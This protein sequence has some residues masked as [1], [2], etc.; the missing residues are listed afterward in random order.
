MNTALKIPMFKITKWIT[1]QN[2]TET[3]LDL[4]LRG[5]VLGISNFSLDLLLSYIMITDQY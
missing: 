4:M 5:T 2:I 1:I 3:I